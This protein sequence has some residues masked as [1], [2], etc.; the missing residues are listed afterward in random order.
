MYNTIIDKSDT[1]NTVYLFDRAKNEHL[2]NCVLCFVL[3][4]EYHIHVVVSCKYIIEDVYS[5]SYVC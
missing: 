1:K 4:N 5:V 2:P 3:I